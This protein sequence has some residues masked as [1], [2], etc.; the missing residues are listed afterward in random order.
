MRNMRKEE[1]GTENEETRNE[2]KERD[3]PSSHFCLVTR[4][5]CLPG[6]I[7]AHCLPKPIATAR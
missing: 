4:N 6:K 1:G 2:R 5:L 7:L 3:S